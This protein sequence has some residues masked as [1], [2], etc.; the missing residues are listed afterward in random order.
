MGTTCII[1]STIPQIL[2]IGYLFICLF[3][4]LRSKG[5]YSIVDSDISITFYFAA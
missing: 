2:D 5:V 4:H 3:L 1:L